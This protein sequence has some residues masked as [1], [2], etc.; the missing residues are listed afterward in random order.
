MKKVWHGVSFVALALVFALAL[1]ALL[2]GRQAALGRAAD[3]AKPGGGPRYSVIETQ[4]HNLLVADNGA[5]KLY[6]YTTDMDAPI[7][8]PLKLRAS[9]DLTK[10][11]RPEITITP[12]NLEKMRKKNPDKGKEK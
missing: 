3:E 1:T 10:V 4:G 5:N 2:G 8:S 12:H 11:G 7:G 9:L 6:Y